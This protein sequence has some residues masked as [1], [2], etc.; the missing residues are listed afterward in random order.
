VI[1]PLL[2]YWLTINLAKFAQEGLAPILAL[3]HMFLFVYF[4][5]VVV[6]FGREFFKVGTLLN[7]EL[8]GID[9]LAK[10]VI[11]YTVVSGVVGYALAWR[12]EKNKKV[13]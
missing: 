2:I 6:L 1:A 11:F 8:G 12:V 13:T 5:P 10:T 3:I 4:I 7:I 9:S